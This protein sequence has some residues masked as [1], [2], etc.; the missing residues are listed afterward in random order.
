MQT[1]RAISKYKRMQPR[2]ARLVAGLI[3]GLPIEEAL[4]QLTFCP[5]KPAREIKKTLES[6]IANGELQHDMR[7]ENM[8]VHEIRIDE[9]P[10]FK[11]AKS[12]SKGGKAPVLKKTSHI[13]IVVGDA[14]NKEQRS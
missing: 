2:K 13:T 9:G 1:A 7:R 11:R 4:G 12:K 6:A 10:Y 14:Q 5:M 8:R 3:R